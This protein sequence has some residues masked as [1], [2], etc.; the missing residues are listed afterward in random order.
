MRAGVIEAALTTFAPDLLIVDKVARGVHGELDRA[1]P[2]MRALHGTTTVLGLRDVL[3][4]PATTIR[5]WEEL[6][7]QDAV[8]DLY[9]AIW[10]Y[11]DPALFDPAVEYGWPSSI[12]SKVS[13]TGYLSR[14]RSDHLQT[15]RRRPPADVDQAF[16]LGL[17]GGGQDGAKVARAFAEATFP[18]GHTG[19]LVTG[20]YIAPQ[21]LDEL[22]GLELVRTDLQVLDFVPDVPAYVS[23]SAATVSMGGYNSVCE[24]LATDRPALLVPR[25]APRTEQAI[26][27]ERLRRAGLVDIQ[28]LSTVTA[29]GVTDWLSTAVGR[30]RLPGE[31]I[32]L[33]G[34]ARL[35]RLATRLLE[36]PAHRGSIG[37][38]HHVA[39]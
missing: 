11:G 14:G 24:L 22:R 5:E 39:V 18:T 1:L 9:D 19:V 4:G 34:L 36:R 31:A 29:S 3:D 30:P 38:L 6:R 15:T 37:A 16:V 10:V 27:A 26:R 20:P 7:T 8:R 13:Y 33:D 32:D 23:R 25:T 17:V 28:D 35:P 21:V 12:T 2:R